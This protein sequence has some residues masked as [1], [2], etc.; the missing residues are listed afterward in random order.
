MHRGLPANAKP[1]AT[2]WL[3]TDS[4]GRDTF[5]RLVYG[6]RVSL[7]AGVVTIAIGLV[8]GGSIGLIA[9]FRRGRAETFLMAIVDIFL[10][11]PALVLPSPSSPCSGRPDERRASPSPWW[12]SP[13]SPAS[14]GPPRSPT[15]SA[16]SCSAA[17]VD[18]RQERAG[19]CCG[20]SCPNVILPLLA[21][22]L[23]V[24]AIAIVAEGSLAFLGLSVEGPERQLGQHDRRRPRRRSSD[25]AH[26]SSLIAV[27][28]MFLTVL[29]VNFLGDQFRAAFDVQDAAL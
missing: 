2:H 21:F 11:F 23:L 12:R 26:T 16:S 1:S 3:G 13:P 5:A 14:R 10:A 19:S 6:A 29:A 24:I 18:G 15:P 20:R 22:A 7:I 25:I 17:A 9:G 4:S 27:G 8:V 28:V